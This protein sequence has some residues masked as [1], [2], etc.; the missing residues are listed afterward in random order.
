MEGCII[1]SINPCF[2]K[3]FKAFL[4]PIYKLGKG[5]NDSMSSSEKRIAIQKNVTA[6]DTVI[7]NNEESCTFDVV[8]ERRLPASILFNKT[9]YN[10]LIFRYLILY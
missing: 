8:F 2:C 10:I 9:P 4:L 7:I 6:V 5:L 1:W 3:I